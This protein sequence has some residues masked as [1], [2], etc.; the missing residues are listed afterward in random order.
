MEHI[1]WNTPLRTLRGEETTLA[2]YEGKVLMVVNTASKCGLTPQYEGLEALHKE[3]ADAGLVILGFP[4]D[5]FGNQEPGSADEIGAFCTANYGVTF[6][7]FEKTDVNGEH[8]H[9]LFQTLKR[10][11]PGLLGTEGIK[12]NF[13]KFLVGRD[14]AVLRRFGPTE[15]PEAIAPKVREALAT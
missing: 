13:T 14:G 8:T 2:R 10:A 6:P 12:W 15:T 11:A 1:D 4:C 7:M 3:L 9:P 5:Q